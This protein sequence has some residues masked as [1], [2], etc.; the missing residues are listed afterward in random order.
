MDAWNSVIISQ[1]LSFKGMTKRLDEVNRQSNLD[2]MQPF[3]ILQQHL[4]GTESPKGSNLCL[5]T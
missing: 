4:M 2:L 5:S 3:R 1:S